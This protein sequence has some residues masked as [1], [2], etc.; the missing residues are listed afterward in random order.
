MTEL[1][2]IL[3]LSEDASGESHFDNLT[4]ARSL[5]DFVPPA[6]LLFIS[7]VEKASGYAVL[8]LPVG[9]VGERHPSPL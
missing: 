3:R 2:H 8:R 9:W 1:L 4:I 6:H 7:T 5:Q